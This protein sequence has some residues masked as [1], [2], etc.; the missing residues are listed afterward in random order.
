MDKKEKQLVD[1]YYG[2]FSERSFDE[3][4]LYGFLM[5]VREHSRDQQVI[6]DLQISL[7]IERIVRAMRKRI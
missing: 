1:Y 3:K 6:R 7:Y 4:D 2:K 5:V